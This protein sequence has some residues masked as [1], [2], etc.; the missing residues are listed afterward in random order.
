MF[1]IAL[2]WITLDTHTVRSDHPNPNQFKIH[3]L[4]CKGMAGTTPPSKPG[5]GSSQKEASSSKSLTKHASENELL[6]KISFRAEHHGCTGFLPSGSDLSPEDLAELVVDMSD[7]MKKR[8]V[9]KNWRCK[10][11]E[12]EVEVDLLTVTWEKLR[13][14]LERAIIDD[15][16][17]GSWWDEDYKRIY[18]TS[19]L[20]DEAGK[21]YM[22]FN[23]E[24][25]EEHEKIWAAL[26]EIQAG[27]RKGHIVIQW[28]HKYY[29][30]GGL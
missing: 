27:E 24:E 10:P 17:H 23:F 4:N 30:K 20:W 5:T 16:D 15:Y 26:R 11:L 12:G 22:S 18:H 9:D 14:K 21:P 6:F 25:L 29:R 19:F 7:E 3:P 1:G 2:S 13:E 28:V 8:G